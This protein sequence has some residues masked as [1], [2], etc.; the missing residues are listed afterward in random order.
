MMTDRKRTVDR[1][2]E[3]ESRK[4]SDSV[5]KKGLD[6]TTLQREGRDDSESERRYLE[7]FESHLD[8]KVIDRLE[9]RYGQWIP[10]ERL[11]SCRKRSLHYETDQEFENRLTRL[12]P[13]IDSKDLDLT[14]GYFNGHEPHVRRN[15][16]AL[17]TNVHERLHHLSDPRAAELLGKHLY[18]GMTEELAEEERDFQI[19]LWSIE[20]SSNGHVTV[21]EP[22][23]FYREEKITYRHLREHVPESVLMEAYFQGDIRRLVQTLD[24]KLGE[25]TWRELRD[26]LDKTDRDPDGEALSKIRRLLDPRRGR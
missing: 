20:R 23:E 6:H 26:L 10:P 16:E 4:V 25:G 12:N 14:Q 19:K 9:I 11:A 24:A 3:K 17:A 22:L 21:M 7:A 15:R 2:E 5:W 18:E 1:A 13:E 8:A